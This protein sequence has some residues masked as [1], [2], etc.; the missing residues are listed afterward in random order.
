M[1]TC[2]PVLPVLSCRLQAPRAP[3]ATGARPGRSS[4]SGQ[5][6]IAD[7]VSGIMTQQTS[8]PASRVSTRKRLLQSKAAGLASASASADA[9]DLPSKRRGRPASS[10]RSNAAN[11]IGKA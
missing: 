11:K 6:D 7:N 8:E 3:S 9:P 10:G 4:E 2:C 5:D 1:L